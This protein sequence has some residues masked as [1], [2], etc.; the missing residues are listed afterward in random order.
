M[1]K[2]Y[3]VLVGPLFPVFFVGMWCLVLFQLSRM[4][5]WHKLSK[6]FESK[7]KVEGKY[8]RFQSASMKKINFGSSLEVGVNE[9]GLILVPFIIFRLFHKRLFIPWHYI[10]TEKVKRFFFKGYRLTFKEV[11]GVYLEVSDR[12][13]QKMEKYL[14]QERQQAA[15]G[16]GTR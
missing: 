6:F 11:N 8:Y 16:D 2:F 4:S 13:Y 3:E 14:I 12:L 7:E 9:I 15:G 1:D 5:G 10:E